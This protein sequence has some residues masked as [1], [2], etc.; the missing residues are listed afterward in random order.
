MAKEKKQKEHKVRPE[1]TKEAAGVESDE[2]LSINKANDWAK[3]RDMWAQSR[4]QLKKAEAHADKFF[5][6]DDEVPLSHHMI[7]IIVLA[8]FVVFVLWA[9]IATLDEVARGDGKVIP[10]QEIQTV[11]SFEGGI[12]ESFLVRDGQE[13]EAGQPIARL[14]DVQATSDL[15]ANRQRYLG[16]KAQA[17][18]LNAESEGLITPEFSDEVMA[19]VPES[20]SEEMETFRANQRNLLNQIQVLDRQMDQR[21]QEVTEIRDRIAD[22]KEVIQLSRE[23]MSMI[24]PLV[25]RGSAPKVELLQLERGIKEQM[26][27]LNS[28]Q[29]T[30]PTSEQAVAEAKARIAEVKS[31]ARAQAQT[32][33][34]ATQIEMNSIQET[35]AALQDRKVR[36]LIRSPVAGTIQD[37]KINTVGGVVQPGEPIVEIVP[38]DD[39]LII[40]ARINPKDRAFIHPG[41]K[42]VVKITAYDY[43]IYGGLDGELYDISADSITNEKDETYYRVRIRTDQSQL[44]RKGEQLDIVPGMVAT[45]DI[46]TGEKTVMDYI[47][48]PLKK[49]LNN[50]LSER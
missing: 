8:F 10:S 22:L 26:T 1:E 9:N 30:L 16:L 45:V 14:Q 48:K 49:T 36:T 50:S 43:S 3:I 12:I 20:V 4:E 42:A 41:Q 32:E 6:S 25:E 35:L 39:Q 33:L 40:E 46:L 15:G 21:Q 11:Q 2:V 17:E 24:R 28:L 38:K 7:L 37:F 47:L 23:E 29:N 5:N 18:R 31:A 27:E 34:S 44:V 19:G 13:V